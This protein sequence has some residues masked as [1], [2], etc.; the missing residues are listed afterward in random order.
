MSREN[1]LLFYRHLE[2]HPE[3]REKALDLQK[4]HS[5]QEKVIDEFIR[6]AGEEGFPFTFPEFMET[7][8][9]IAKGSEQ[10]GPVS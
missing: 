7:M 9:S 4:L 3:V 5:E 10:D 2:T 1:I 6:L 8:Y